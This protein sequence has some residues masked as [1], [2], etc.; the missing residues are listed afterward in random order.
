[1]FLLLDP[2]HGKRLHQVFHRE[3]R[4]VFAVQ[5]RVYKVRRQVSQAQDPADKRWADVLGF[6]DVRDRG[7]RAV[8]QLA[9]PAVAV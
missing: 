2:L 4:R 6:V 8:E 9:V 5:D 7:M 3:V 1:M